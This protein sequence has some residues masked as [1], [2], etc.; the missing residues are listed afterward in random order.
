MWQLLIIYMVYA[1]KITFYIFAISFKLLWSLLKWEGRVIK[2]S[3]RRYPIGFISFFFHFFGFWAMMI[4][5]KG[6]NSEFIFRICTLGLC[7]DIDSYMNVVGFPLVWLTSI[8]FNSTLKAFIVTIAMAFLM[9]PG[10]VVVIE[11]TF[12]LFPVLY[13]IFTQLILGIPFR[14]FV[15]RWREKHDRVLWEED[16]CEAE[17]KVYNSGQCVV[18]TKTSTSNANTSNIRIGPDTVTEDGVRL[19][20][21][22]IKGDKGPQYREFDE[23]YHNVKKRIDDYTFK[24]YHVHE[25]LVEKCEKNEALEKMYAQTVSMHNEM[26]QVY[27]RAYD[28][29]CFTNDQ[30]AIKECYAEL[31]KEMIRVKNAQA[32]LTEAIKR[33]YGVQV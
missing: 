30:E 18:H 29:V 22:V 32:N 2:T 24:L 26:Q 6:L 19:S 5:A 16:Y 12:I 21:V 7:K 25:Q 14:S 31:K 15:I 3:F 28:T 4:L 20:S 13:A 8:D 17:E 1:F 27:K 10:V 23:T 33:V 9:I 11:S